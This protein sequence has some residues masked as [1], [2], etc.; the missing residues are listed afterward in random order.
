MCVLV[1][2]AAIAGCG[3]SPT[4]PNEAVQNYLNAL[5][6]GNYTTAC[7]LLD[8]RARESLI[9]SIRVR[10]TCPAVF[11]RCLPHR[12]TLLKQDQTQL[13][14]ANMQ[15]SV[16]GSDATAAVSGTAVAR[17]LKHV[18]VRDEQTGWMVT[19]LGQAIERCRLIRGQG[20]RKVAAIG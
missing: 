19:G 4:P 2:V 18:T 20:Q 9:R 17:E 10:T 15:V 14:Y 16:T 7:S 5:G 13:L 6:A 11:R 12:T 1:L 8:S 3:E